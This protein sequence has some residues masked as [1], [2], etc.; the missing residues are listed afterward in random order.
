MDE[1]E[2]DDEFYFESAHIALRSNSDYLKVMKHLTVLCSMRIKVHSDIEVLSAA[3]KTALD[4]PEGFVKDI[5]QG[6]TNLPGQIKIPEV[7]NVSY[8]ISVV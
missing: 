4:D 8:I 1:S 5:S 2:D 3:Q 6:S 7:R